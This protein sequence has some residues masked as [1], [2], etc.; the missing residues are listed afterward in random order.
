[1][2]NVRIA[3]EARETDRRERLGIGKEKLLEELE[4]EANDA[5][6]MFNNIANK[7]MGIL[8]YNDPLHINEDIV[9]QKEKCDDLIRQKD[10]LI[11]KLRAELRM[12]ELNFS[13]DQRKQVEDINS[14]AR[15][16]ENQVSACAEKK[17]ILVAFQ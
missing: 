9:S 4:E 2:T 8:K 15:R 6:Q 13:S 5:Q 1:M 14:L 16:I 12:A 3:N 17:W 11:E 7:W 10:A